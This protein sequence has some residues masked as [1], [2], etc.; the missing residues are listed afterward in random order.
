MHLGIFIAVDGVDPAAANTDQIL[1]SHSSENN[2]VDHIKTLG[3]NTFGVEDQAGLGDRDFND[4]VISF[5][6]V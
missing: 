2:N 6:V 4:I 1:F 3:D 5:N